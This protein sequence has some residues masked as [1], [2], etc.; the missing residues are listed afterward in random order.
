MKSYS[1]YNNSSQTQLLACADSIEQLEEISQHYEDG[2]WFEYDVEIVKGT[3]HLYNERPYNFKNFPD[4]PK[5]RERSNIKGDERIPI[6][7][8]V[9]T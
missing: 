4:N 5:P 8:G 7:D 1:L 6:K 3:E 9:L 2:V